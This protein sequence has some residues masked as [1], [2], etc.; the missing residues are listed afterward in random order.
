MRVTYKRPFAQFVKKSQKPLQL[1]IEG[2]VT[3]ICENPELGRQKRGDLKDVFVYKFHFNQQEFLI[4]YQFE[5]G[6][7]TLKIVWIDFYQIGSHENFYTQLKKVIR[8][9]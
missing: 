9:I 3:K 1:T 4:A 6:M 5:Y 8:L 7:K 2:E